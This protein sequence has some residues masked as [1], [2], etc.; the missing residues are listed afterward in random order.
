MTQPL[1]EL[2]SWCICTSLAICV[3]GLITSFTVPQETDSIP[4]G[5]FLI[6]YKI[7]STSRKISP[8]TRIFLP[9]LI[10]KAQHVP[11]YDYIKLIFF[12]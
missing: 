7:L 1:N 11:Y 2:E 9:T 12:Y 5:I 8:E 4:L 3:T 6:S 10:R